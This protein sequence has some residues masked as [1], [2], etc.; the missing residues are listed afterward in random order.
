MNS[1]FGKPL[2]GYLFVAPF[3][4]GF[5]LTG[6]WPILYTF[7]L[8]L[9]RWD[10]F[11]SPVNAGA[12]NFDRLV[13]DELFYRTL[14]NTLL[15]WLLSIVPQLILAL[16]L[17]LVLN[18][19][20]IRGRSFYRAAFYFPH[21][22]TPIALGVLIS[23][24]FDWK[25]GAVNQLLLTIG[26]IRDPVNWFDSPGWSRLILA[27]VICWQYFGMNLLVFLAGLQS[28]SG[29]VLEAARMDGATGLT[30][31]RRVTLPLLRPVLLF[32]LLTSVVGGLQLFDAPLMV[33]D[34][35]DHA[36]QTMMMYLFETAFTHFNFSYGAAI[37]CGIFVV[38]LFFTS[39]T[40]AAT[41]ARE[42]EAGS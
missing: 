10:G 35:P 19:R 32:T 6:L 8:S 27:S 15:I 4:I 18:Q 22:V 23:L 34:G 3:F 24:A 20:F 7:H 37:A 33:G 30:L 31:L 14:G 28:I 2:Y 5:A 21:V 42:R 38:I 12:A 16:G 26:L 1:K 25:S 9:T 36:T 11:G 40:A 13:R 41:R 29:E 39:L 17:A